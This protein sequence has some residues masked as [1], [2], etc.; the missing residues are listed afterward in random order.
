[1]CSTSHTIPRTAVR[2]FVLRYAEENNSA[3]WTHPGYTTFSFFPPR[4][5]L[6]HRTALESEGTRLCVTPSFAGCGSTGCCTKPMSDLCWTCQHL[7][8]GLTTDLWRRS[9][10][11]QQ[12]IHTCT[13]A[14]Y[15]HVIEII[16]LYLQALRRSEEH[17]TLVTQERFVYRHEIGPGSSPTSA[18]WMVSSA[19]TLSE[20]IQGQSSFVRLLWQIGKE[21]VAGCMETIHS[22]QPP[23]I[24]VTERRKYL[25]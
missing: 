1:M 7:L 23:S 13:C 15:T 21:I 3:A 19:F 12:C 18:A 22:R 5:Q 4:A 16:V 24:S 6:Y 17:L 14:S 10:P 9:L 20:T 25:Y 8:C 2:E 11:A